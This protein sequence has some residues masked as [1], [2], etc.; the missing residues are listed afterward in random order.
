[1][2]S[3]HIFLVTELVS[4]FVVIPIIL[5]LNIHPFIKL[6][7]VLIGVLYC[8]YTSIKQHLFS[9]KELLEIKLHKV[10]KPITIQIGLFVIGSTLLMYF[11]NNE[12][13]FIVLRKNWVI[14]LAITF[15][16]S[17]FSVYPQEFL[18]RTFFFKRYSIL[19]KNSSVLIVIN[20]LVF[21]IAHLVFNNL[22]VLGLTFIGGILFAF[23]YNK[24]KSLLLTSIEHAFY[25]SWLFTLGMGEMLAFPIPN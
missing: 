24:S 12:N 14:W 23:T 5:S 17:V 16:Y 8:I 18:Y 19:F 20:A 11:F 1:M 3:K 9:L 21:S 22:L 15:F 2:T 13:L 10:W 25:G 7:P 4:L 6:T